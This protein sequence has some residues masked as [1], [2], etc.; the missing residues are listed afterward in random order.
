M[1]NSFYLNILRTHEFLTENFVI[2]H[3][4]SINWEVFSD[5]CDISKYSLDFFDRFKNNIRWDK[6][7][8]TNNVNKEFLQKFK[9]RIYSE[10]FCD[11]FQLVNEHEYF[12]EEQ[13]YIDYLRSIRP[14]FLEEYSHLFCWNILSCIFP[15]TLQETEKYQD[16]IN[17]LEYTFNNYKTPEIIIKFKQNLKESSLNN[18]YE[19][20]ITN[21]FCNLDYSVINHEL[22]HHYIDDI[23][24]LPLMTQD[25]IWDNISRYIILEKEMI[26]EYLDFL[27]LSIILNRIAIQKS[28]AHNEMVLLETNKITKNN[29]FYNR[30]D[31]KI[32]EGYYLSDEFI[33]Q[34]IVPKI[35]KR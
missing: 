34:V 29:I 8:W 22:V 32:K 17:W 11:F 27:N 28:E 10:N 19:H 5:S 24:E 2:N 16:K 3:A 20:Y 26:I 9:D 21:I 14:T 33:K 18:D 15:F 13:E 1:K 30:E 4:D 6:I 35:L 23:F 7:N 31:V 25:D 12:G